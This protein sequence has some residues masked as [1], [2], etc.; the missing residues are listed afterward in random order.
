VPS[1]A[2]TRNIAT[3]ILVILLMTLGFAYNFRQ[4]MHILVSESAYRNRTTRSATICF[5]ANEGI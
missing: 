4:R 1:V 2:K 3:R 5:A